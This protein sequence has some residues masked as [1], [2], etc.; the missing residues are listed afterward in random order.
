MSA[1]MDNVK[2]TVMQAVTNKKFIMIVVLLALFIGLAFWVYTTYVAPKLNPEY[3]DNKEYINS[4]EGG[5]DDVTTATV[6]AF[7]TDWCPHCKKSIIAKDSGWK[8]TVSKLN[9]QK[10]NGILV[11]FVEV[12]GETDSGTLEYFEQEHKVSI[13]A[14]PTIYLVKG[15]NVIEY[16]T[17]ITEDN[18]TEFLNQAL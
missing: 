12:N 14:F 7:Y 17:D 1:M 8:K 13:E 4:D 18:L 2:N 10:I 6:Y 11:N 16:T 3:K 15:N 9:E 5:A